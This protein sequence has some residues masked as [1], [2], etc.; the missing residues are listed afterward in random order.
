M[1]EVGRLFLGIFLLIFLSSGIF[2]VGVGTCGVVSRSSCVAANGDNIVMGLSATT[3]AHAQLASIGTYSYVLCCNFADPIANLTCTTSPSNEIIGLSA[4]TNAHAEV[5]SGT[6]YS[7]PICYRG[8]VCGKYTACP[9][10][11]IEVLSLSAD[12]NAHVGTFATYNT[13]ICCG[14]ISVANSLCKIKSATW[15][16][17]DSIVGQGI[18]LVVTGSSSSDCAGV[19]VSFN[20]L[21]KD[22][23]SYQK[24][25]TNPVNVAFNGATATGMWYSEYQDDGLL[26]GDPEYVFNVSIVK[27]PKISKLSSN[28]LS[29]SELS[30]NGLD[31]IYC[32]SVTTCDDYNNQLE[33]ES[34]A[35]LCKVANAS[36]LPEVDCDSDST[37]C[38]CLWN[39]DTSTCGFNWGEIEDCGTPEDGCNYGCTLCKNTTGNYCNL[40]STCPTG[41]IPTSNNNGTCDVGEGCLSEDCVDGDTDT[42]ASVLYCLSGECSTVENP[43]ILG[44]LGNCQIK[45]TVEKGCDEEPTGYK[46]IT[47]TGTW[48]GEASGSS[49]ERC[50]AGGKTTI[51][52]AAQVQLPFFD[53]FELVATL[54]VL[55]I[56]YFA[57]L[58]KKKNHK[59]K[60]RK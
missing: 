8:F 25:T 50:V 27:N 5:P 26:G 12:T 28:E 46:I 57:L 40:G 14:G 9:D 10:K 20:V 37:V 59:K 33:C 7:F 29:V 31:E 51:P 6:A 35:S 23:G 58:Y 54:V 24:V 19:T 18:R 2:A 36:S 53:Y 1:K 41:E 47:W 38:G 13:K 55:T 30:V 48:T 11:T 45:Q 42:C 39:D 43:I 17:T 22:T 34:D 15:S 3:D 21:E 32:A 56:I 16:I 60:S 52:C 4:T 49:Y 44:L